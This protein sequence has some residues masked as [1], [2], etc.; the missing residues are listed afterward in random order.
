[1]SPPT[2]ASGSI[3]LL[4]RWDDGRRSLVGLTNIIDK[5]ILPAQQTKLARRIE[6]LL[7]DEHLSAAEIRSGSLSGIPA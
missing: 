6:S 4:P 3:A 7:A 1:M 2:C 5:A